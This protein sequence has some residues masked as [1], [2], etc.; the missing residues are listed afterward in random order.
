LQKQVTADD[1]LAHALLCA[2]LLVTLLAQPPARKGTKPA[3][4]VPLGT[5]EIDLSPLL[6]PRC[7]PA[8][9]LNGLY[10]KRVRMHKRSRLATL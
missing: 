1:R 6:Q 10:L 5:A 4:P 3:Q 2:P 8:A 9:S 7:V